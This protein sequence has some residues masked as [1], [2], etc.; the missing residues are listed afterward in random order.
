MSRFT[1]NNNSDLQI[2]VRG[3]LRVRVFRTEHTLFPHALGLEG[4]NFRSVR[5]QNLKLVLVVVLVLQS[6][7]RY[8]L[9]R[10]LSYS[11]QSSC[12]EATQHGAWGCTGMQML[13]LIELHFTRNKRYTEKDAFGIIP[14][15]I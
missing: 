1:P 9:I 7:G 2:A 6:E 5:A 12:C 14:I 13:A 3:R 4:D 15:S 8:C 10:S 11:T